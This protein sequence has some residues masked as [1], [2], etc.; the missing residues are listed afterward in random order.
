[1]GERR[2]EMDHDRDDRDRS[3]AQQKDRRLDLSV[4]Q[5][6]GSALAAV[7]AAVLASRL[8]VYGT[9]IGAGVVSVVATCGG[10]VFQ[11]LFRRTGE[12]IRDAATHPRSKVRQEP[13]G[14]AREDPPHGEFGEA[15]T[16]G[17]RVR[18]W[19]RSAL[20]AA[21][22][23]GVAM[24]GITGYELASGQDLGGGRGT[25]VGS[26]V[27]GG[28]DGKSAPEESPSGTTPQQNRDGER[29]A[30]GGSG[31]GDDRSPGGNPGRHDGTGNDT[32]EGSTGSGTGSGSA[33]GGNGQDDGSGAS[34]PAPGPTPSSG[35]QDPAPAPTSTPPPSMSPPAGADGPDVP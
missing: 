27:R 3:A 13:A 26:A 19:K 22:V 34:G 6:A 2:L 33:T 8:G 10:S 9:V 29:S 32:G 30:P 7:A 16:H 11:H 31:S 17:T 1:M 12:Q 21:V 35:G 5:V 18:G 28:G 23:F 25:T 4:P 15:T 20:A 14:S 24:I